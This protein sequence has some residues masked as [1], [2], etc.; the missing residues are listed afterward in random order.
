MRICC[1]SSTVI[2]KVRDGRSAAL[3]PRL[4]LSN[5]MDLDLKYGQ[6]S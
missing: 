3:S 6:A 5:Y 1:Q 2:N 4:D